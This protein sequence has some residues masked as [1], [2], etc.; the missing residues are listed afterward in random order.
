MRK[1]LQLN[2][3]RLDGRQPKDFR[4]VS[5]NLSRSEA[6]SSAEILLGSTRAIT[7]VKGSIC[8]PFPDRP[9]EGILQISVDISESGQQSGVF[10]AEV[11]TS[12]HP[13]G[14]PSNNYY[15]VLCM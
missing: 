15:M 14:L 11:I 5:F 13:D 8:P 6:Y 4:P 2:K 9:T 12:L 3:I 10:H 7:V 1:S